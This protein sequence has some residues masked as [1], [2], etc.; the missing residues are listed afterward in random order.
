MKDV[1]VQRLP[2]REQHYGPAQTR[3]LDRGS[4]RTRA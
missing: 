1:G 2:Q 4:V 3:P